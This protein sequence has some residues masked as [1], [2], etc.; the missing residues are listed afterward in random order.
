MEYPT[1]YDLHDIEMHY[2]YHPSDTGASG[3][4]PSAAGG[5]E[6]VHDEK[7][8][9][10]RIPKT[11]NST[12]QDCDTL[13]YIVLYRKAHPFWRTK[14]EVFVNKNTN[15]LP[16]LE[17]DSGKQYSILTISFPVFIQHDE[18]AIM[19]PTYRFAGYYGIRAI[20]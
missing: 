3:L 13:A 6:S 11:L 7:K 15:L 9:N 18:P 2:G 10:A 1:C 12:K 5:A 17:G 19:T 16:D 14:Q 4:E 8:G 20:R